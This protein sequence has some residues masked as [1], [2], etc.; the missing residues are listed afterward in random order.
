M[1]CTG[2]EELEYAG[3]RMGNKN[4][5]KKW[6]TVELTNGDV[7]I[8]AKKCRAKS[9]MFAMGTND[10]KTPGYSRCGTDGKSDIKGC[11]CYCETGAKADGTCTTTTHNGYR[12]YTYQKGN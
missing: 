9:S 4:M 3:Y 2:S 1:E 5:E 7:E 12:L 6:R 8:C 11:V 10:F